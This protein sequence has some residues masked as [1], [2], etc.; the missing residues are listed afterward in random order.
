LPAPVENA[1]GNMGTL[2]NYINVEESDERAKDN[3]R[4][5]LKYIG[6][7]SHLKGKR[8]TGYYIVAEDIWYFRPNGA[9]D[10]YRVK[11]ENLNFIGGE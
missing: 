4:V 6:T 7:L 3:K 11:A 8:G 1:I 5:D 10:E 9:P 2:Q